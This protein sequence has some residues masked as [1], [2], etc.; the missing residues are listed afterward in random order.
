MLSRI[1]VAV[2]GSE[3]GEKAFN[4]ALYIAKKFESYLLIA[5]IVEEYGNIGQSIVNELEQE[6][7][8]LLQEYQSRAENLGLPSSN[9][10][11]IQERAMDVARRILDIAEKES[12]E[13]IV[14]GSRGKYLSSESFLVGSTSSKLV[15]YGRYT[16][17][18]VK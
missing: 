11:V 10:R 1:I 3:G 5:H 18:I 8:R 2:D 12:M 16:V 4:F 6:G 7:Q 9:M 17:I 14:V 13:T 15:H